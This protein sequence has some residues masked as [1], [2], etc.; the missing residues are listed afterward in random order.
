MKMKEKAYKK[1]KVYKGKAVDFCNDTVILPNN[2]KATRE[3]IDH[4]G[5][6]AVVPFV[7]KTDII[8]VKQFRYPVNEITYEIPAGKLD[9]KES[10]LKC[11]KRELGEETGYKTKNIKKLISFWPSPAFSNEE[12]YIYTAT[13]LIPGKS[14]PDS[15]EFVNTVIIPFKKALQMIYNGK[16]KDSKTIIALTVLASSIKNSEV[17]K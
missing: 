11:A 6:V 5:A 15:D 9:K 8:F 2:K 3:Y 16:I 4:P 7:N 13:N 12:L 17:I 14:H 10:L 1:N